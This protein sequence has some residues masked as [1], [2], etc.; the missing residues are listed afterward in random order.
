MKQKL[1][2][3]I[4]SDIDDINTDEE[5]TLEDIEY[6]ETF[7][8]TQPQIEP[9]G[10]LFNDIMEAVQLKYEEENTMSKTNCKK[11]IYITI[12][13]LLLNVRHQVS[14]LDK[15]FWMISFIIL[16]LGYISLKYSGDISIILLGPVVSVFSIY[17]LYRGRYYNVFEMEA[18]CK[19]SM[20][21][22]TLART[23]IILIY[24]IV[25]ATILAIINYMMWNI[26]I[27]AFL[28]LTWLSPLLMSYYL[29]LY[30][31]YKKGVIHSMIAN[32]IAWVLYVSSF[33][34]FLKVSQSNQSYAYG[35]EV[36]NNTMWININL[37]L[38]LV[39]TMMLGLLFKNIKK[40]Y[41]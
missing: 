1:S 23:V 10:S 37:V 38:I 15:R 40:I 24:N 33:Q 30:F 20:Y 11:D 5:I 27:W 17:Y 16:F 39:S 41:G 8:K 18:V 36:Y 3:D 13:N 21:E 2:D 14:L 29:T 32:G 28:I 9:P 34:F 26:N 22:I 7:L 35:S 19:Y 25:F 31:F 12:K 6:I 4:L